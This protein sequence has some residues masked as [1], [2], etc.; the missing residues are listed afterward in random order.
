LCILPPLPGAPGSTGT[1]SLGVVAGVAVAVVLCSDV[2]P[3]FSVP[4]LQPG[5]HSASTR[6]RVSVRLDI[7]D[8]F[9]VGSKVATRRKLAHRN[10]LRNPR[11]RREWPLKCH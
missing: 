7:H 4:C 10:R 2:E 9:R 11:P 5:T 6:P 8:S 3:D 1:A